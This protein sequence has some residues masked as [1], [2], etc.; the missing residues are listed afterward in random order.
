[1]VAKAGSLEEMSLHTLEADRQ[2]RQQAPPVDWDVIAEEGAQRYQAQWDA[3]P[4]QPSKLA[5]P[6]PL[7]RFPSPPSSPSRV[8]MHWLQAHAGPL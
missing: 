7:I 2:L 8:H 1:M 3:E 4:G 6:R 5:P